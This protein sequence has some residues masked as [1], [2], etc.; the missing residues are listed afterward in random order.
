[1]KRYNKQQWQHQ[2]GILESQMHAA[3]GW[4]V[5]MWQAVLVLSNFEHMT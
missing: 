5:E 3:W 4:A 1:V 2:H